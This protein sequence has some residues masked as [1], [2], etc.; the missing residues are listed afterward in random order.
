M[1]ELKKMGSDN[2]IIFKSYKKDIIDDISRVDAVVLPSSKGEG[3][4]RIIIEAM[5]LGKIVIVSDVPPHSEILGNEL[6]EFIFTVGDEARLK[7]IIERLIN[8]KE[9]LSEK[10]KFIREK[11]VRLFD[12]RKNTKDTEAIYE[13]Y[14]FNKAS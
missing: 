5:A 7:E 11:A 2:R 12:V 1:E 8:S 3:L 4:P 9:T 6:R 14:T 10:A 13:E